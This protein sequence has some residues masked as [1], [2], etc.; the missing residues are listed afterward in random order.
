MLLQMDNANIMAMLLL[1]INLI[2]LFHN[3]QQTVFLA[4]I[5]LMGR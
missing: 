4:L 3:A 5:I 2:K 1:C